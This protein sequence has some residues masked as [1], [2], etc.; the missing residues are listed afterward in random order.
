[1]ISCE[2]DHSLGQWWRRPLLRSFGP[3]TLVWRRL[4]CRIVCRHGLCCRIVGFCMT[5]HRGC[6]R[7]RSYGLCWSHL[8]SSFGQTAFR[9]PICSSKLV[10]WR[11]CLL[12]Y[13]RCLHGW[14]FAAGLR[15]RAL[16]P[17]WTCFFAFPSFPCEFFGAGPRNLLGR[18]WCLLSTLVVGLWPTQKRRPTSE[19]A[20]AST[21]IL[22][23]W[24][25]LPPGHTMDGSGRLE[26]A[27]CDLSVS[28]SSLCP[29][30]TPGGQDWVSCPYHRLGTCRQ[31]W[32]HI[33]Q[34]AVTM[35][36]SH[37]CGTADLASSCQS[38][39]R[40]QI[41]PVGLQGIIGLLPLHSSTQVVHSYMAFHQSYLPDAASSLV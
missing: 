25:C 11:S 23:F 3:A 19:V 8:F 33:F 14:C 16:F 32:A 9:C 21:K 26:D 39:L 41:N 7:A 1:M 12:V 34:N 13:Q 18:I 31:F 27:S 15:C 28:L 40:F 17:C 5:G 2:S 38:L 6:G 22:N 35:N 36:T 20:S 30:A 24:V 4:S 37:S 10:S 29:S